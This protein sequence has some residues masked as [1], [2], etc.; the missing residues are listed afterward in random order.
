MKDNLDNEKEYIANF[1][2]LVKDEPVIT[3]S[4]IKEVIKKYESLLQK[5]KAYQEILNDVLGKKVQG[6]G[7]P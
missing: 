4:E 6:K 3:L 1:K 5:L 7:F 2:S